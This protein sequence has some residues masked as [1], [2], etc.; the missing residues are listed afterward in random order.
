MHG[1]LRGH[2]VSPA[3]GNG[4]GDS[5]C[6]ALSRALPHLSA[7]QELDLEFEVTLRLVLSPG[8]QLPRHIN[9]GVRNYQLVG[10]K[11]QQKI[12][13]TFR[14]LTEQE[15]HQLLHKLQDA[16]QQHVIGL[17]IASNLL[18]AFCFDL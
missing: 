12:N 16:P 4:I 9:L 1:Q 17:N 8:E 15:F 5:G 11:L 18:F 10:G 7:L 2:L 6:S 13:E 14:R 3:A